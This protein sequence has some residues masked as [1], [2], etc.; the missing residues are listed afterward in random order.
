[1]LKRIRSLKNKYIHRLQHSA[2]LAAIWRRLM[3]RTTVIAVTGSVGKTTCRELLYQILA[4]QA[5]TYKTRNNENDAYGLPPVLFGLRPWHRFAVIELGASGPGTLAPLASMVS[6]DVAIITTVA[7]TH[8]KNY[9]DVDAIAHEKAE[10]LRFLKPHGVAVLNGDD[11][12]VAAMR[13]LPSQTRVEFGC[14]SNRSVRA[15]DI[16][17]AWPQRL[18]LNVVTRKGQQAVNTQLVGEHWVNSVLAAF[19]VAEQCGVPHGQAAESIARVRPFRGRMQPISLPNGAIAISDQNA[20]LD[21]LEAMIS[22][23]TKANAARKIIVLSDINDTTH[24]SSRARRKLAGRMVAP[25]FDI[26]VFFGQSARRAQNAAIAAG[27][28][29]DN[30]HCMSTLGEIDT[31]LKRT[32]QSGDLLFV[33]GQNLHHLHRVIYMQHGA[34]GCSRETCSIR[35][36]CEICSQLNPQFDLDGAFAR[37]GG[38]RE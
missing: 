17:A 18:Q 21:V 14:E 31:L 5:P 29:P 25:V 22:V 16:S 3:W 36:D 33:K 30:V 11:E 13:T 35:S 28:N 12:R 27:M 7:R 23:A 15:Q 34:I 4:D 6:P 19:A 9:P 38:L 24:T 8:T 37:T 1:M 10:L 20:S 32:L 26:A 2:W